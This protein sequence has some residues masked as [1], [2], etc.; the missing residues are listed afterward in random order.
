M[1]LFHLGATQGDTYVTTVRIDAAPAEPRSL[2]KRIRDRLFGAEAPPQEIDP[3]KALIDDLLPLEGGNI[4]P[5]LEVDRGGMATLE[6]AHDSTLQCEVARKAI[7]R[8]SQYNAWMVANFIREAQITAQLDH[9]HIVPVHEL[10]RTVDGRAFFTMRLIEGKNLQALI[11]EIAPG[12]MEDEKLFDLLTIMVKVCDA[13]ALA[14]SRGVIHCDIK[15]P[16]IITGTFGEVYLMDWGIAQILE[17][18]DPTFLRTERIP[19]R[20]VTSSIDG[21]GTSGALGTPS[22]MSPEQARREPLGPRSDIFS[23]GATLYEALTGR[24]PYTGTSMQ[25]VIERA[26]ACEFLKP[27]LI[28]RGPIAPELERI[29]LKA[30]E[31]RPED[32]YQSAHE[33]Q[34]DLVRFMRG[35]GE[36]PR[37]VYARGD[38]IIREGEVGEE[39]YVILSGRCDVYTSSDG[40]DFHVHSMGPGDGFGETAILGAARRT[41]SVLCREDTV[42]MVVSRA[43]LER[44]VDQMKPW[45]GAFIRTLAQ[46]ASEA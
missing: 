30:M 29:I 44:E 6:A 18:D 40:A 46:R 24:A 37:R 33:I 15:P 10:G 26:K 9:P 22:Y 12:P 45:M 28:A 4:L 11:D 39:A 5:K 16:N 43:I 8:E 27:G 25:E 1:F 32:R 23:L 38:H 19:E 34:R 20:H 14:H 13:L 41:A 17:A 42:V 21:L 7:H 36:F 31:A 35:G 3:V 2:W